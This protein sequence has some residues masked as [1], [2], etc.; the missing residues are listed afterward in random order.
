M[1]EAC[2][3]ELSV[4]EPGDAAAMHSVI[5]TSFAAR[6]PVDPPAAA[7][8]DTV[9]DIA[10]ALE[11]GTGLLAHIDGELV[12][13]L[14]ISISGNRI[15]LHR[16]SVLPKARQHGVAAQLVRGAGML[17][18]DLGAREV[19]L[20]ARAEFPNLVSWW[21]GHGF[22]I[23]REVPLGYMLSRRLPRRFLIPTAA[24]MKEL[25]ERLGRSLCGGDVI[26]VSGD[27]GAGKTTLAQGIGAGLGVEGPI[28]SPTFVL[29]RVH[30]NP[31][32]PALVHVD[33]YR[34]SSAAELEDIDLESSLAE[35]VT[36]IEWGTGIAE[37][38]ADDRLEIDIQRSDDP[39]DDTR[40]VLLTGYGSRWDEI[41][42]NL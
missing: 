21:E 8:S 27:L 15:G 23:E 37:W 2:E 34:L 18:L 39:N 6:P 36:L 17:G 10:A 40:D 14:L 28:V 4:A 35:S 41:L 22:V 31:A 19:E 26:I 20:M 11:S 3:V 33:A 30:P 7:L 32:G 25:G 24:A 29:S 16:V 38:L 13:C 12:G 9:A 5:Q 42:E 1:T